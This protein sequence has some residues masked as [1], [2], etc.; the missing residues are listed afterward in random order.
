[1]KICRL[2]M[3]PRPF[4]KAY[5]NCYHCLSLWPIANEHNKSLEG[6]CCILEPPTRLLLIICWYRY[7]FPFDG[8]S[9]AWLLLLGPEFSV[10]S[11]LF[12]CWLVGWFGLSLG[13]GLGILVRFGLGVLVWF[14]CLFGFL[15][16]CFFSPVQE[17]HFDYCFEQSKGDNRREGLSSHCG[18]N[19]LNKS[20]IVPG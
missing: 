16:F 3:S 13:F 20:L 11:C 19:L 8:S 9:S 14:F 17:M 10:C 7:W 18:K 15:L 2:V 1:M 4:W 5:L 6:N 12:V